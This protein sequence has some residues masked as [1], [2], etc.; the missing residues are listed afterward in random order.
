[1]V[2]I[3]RALW[4]PVAIPVG[5][6]V[7]ALVVHIWGRFRGRLVTVGYT[8]QVQSLA[9][10]ASDATLGTVEVTHNGQLARNLYLVSV[11]I[12]NDSTRDFADFEVQIGFRDG[13]EFL[14]GVGMI[15]G[16]LRILP[17]APDFGQSIVDYLALPPG[18]RTEAARMPLVRNRIFTLPVLNR[19]EV[20]NFAFLVDAPHG[21]FPDLQVFT[22]HEGARLRAR[23]ARPQIFGVRQDLAGWA[24]LAVALLTMGAAAVATRSP[25]GIVITA[26][27][28]GSFGQVLGAAVVRLWRLILQMLS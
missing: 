9:I 10:S 28:V 2:E 19:S 15:Q 12:A 1:L 8:A 7:G 16:S 6:I 5:A 18:Q 21:V 14:S 25:V 13:T 24:G 17:L 23:P 20:A 4:D 22:Q 27:L 3:L 11:Q 26:V